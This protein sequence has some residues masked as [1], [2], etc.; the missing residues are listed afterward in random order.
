MA[1]SRNASEACPVERAKLQDL[2]LMLLGKDHS[3]IE[4]ASMYADINP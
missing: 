1:M 3:A 4:G 2:R